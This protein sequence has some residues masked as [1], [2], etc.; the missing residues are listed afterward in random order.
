MSGAQQRWLKN[1]TDYC[2]LPESEHHTTDHSHLLHTTP[3]LRESVSLPHSETIYKL[4]GTWCDADV[5][6]QW[7][8]GHYFLNRLFET[9]AGFKMLKNG[10]N[11]LLR[12]KG[13]T[14][15][16]ADECQQATG[17]FGIDENFQKK[18]HKCFNTSTSIRAC[19]SLHEAFTCFISIFLVLW[20]S[21][22]QEFRFFMVT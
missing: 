11:T 15:F 13:Y 8:Q 16:F 17:Q 14:M 4:Y 22:I 7:N 21:S 10:I 20:A 3:C 9:L 19:L 12:T 6:K 2:Y 1:Q 5:K 18:T